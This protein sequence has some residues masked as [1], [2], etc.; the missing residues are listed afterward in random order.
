VRAFFPKDGLPAEDPVTGSLN[1]GLGQWLLGTGRMSAPYVATQGS[2]LGRD[3][4][5][6]VSQD[7]DGQVWVAGTT[8]TLV[9]G[10]IAL[11]ST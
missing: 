4:R 3:G 8:R 5:I 1:A 10:T 11:A 2:A 9:D 6:H 7:D